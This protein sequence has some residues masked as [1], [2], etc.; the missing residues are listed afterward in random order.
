MAIT[1]PIIA[2]FNEAGV[3]KAIKQFESLTT[4]TDKAGFIMGK[5]FL[6][7]VAALG[8]ITAAAGFAV[9]AAI[10]D[11]AAQAS[12]ANTLRN[13]TQATDEQIAAT[14]TM[15]S[16]LQM[17]T[18]VADEDL[19]PAYASLTRGTK[20]VDEANKAL[21]LTLDI[22]AGA[23]VSV[24]QTADAL[25]M[26]Y[27]GNMR[28]LAA[29][30]PELKVMIKEG[31]SLDQVMATLS[32]TFAGS[33]ATAA[34]TAQGQFKRLNVALDEAKESIGK[35][36]LPAVLA[37]LPYLV[38]F[39]DWAA[40]NTPIVIGIA[41]AILGI[42]TAI[43]AVNTALALYK[44]AG[45]IAVIVNYALATSFTAANV[46]MTM[47]VA[48][49]TIAAGLVAAT[50][51]MNKFKNEN[52]ATT[53]AVAG[54]TAGLYANSQGIRDVDNAL[55]SEGRARLAS[56]GW[57]ETWN[58]TADKTV[59]GTG[60]LDTVTKKLKVTT[61]DT[62]K[63][64]AD[65]AKTLTNEMNMALD[66]ANAKLV[67]A[68]QT[69]NDFSNSVAGAITQ[70]IDFKAAWE[71]GATSGELTFGTALEEQAEKAKDF[72]DTVKK[73]I[74]AGLSEPALQQVLKA[75]VDAGTL[76]GK[77]LL[78][79]TD[80]ILKANEIVKTLNEIAALVG[81]SAAAA[82]YQSG[83]T[84][85]KAYLQGVADAMASATNALGGASTIADVKGIGATFADTVSNIGAVPTSITNPISVPADIRG[86]TGNGGN[87]NNITINTVTAPAGLGQTIVDALR[88]YEQSNGVVDI[89]FYGGFGSL[90]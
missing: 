6:P 40:R 78:S 37:V 89:N 43:I 69:F 19:R 60:K 21:A 36:L 34:G 74:A 15:I 5:A 49:V 18:G 12:L 13:T 76:I 83:V 62:N 3:Q 7:A 61:E 88:Q 53:T 14:E 46:A 82:F 70:G 48:A 44:V 17:A 73:L 51:A 42:A 87:T 11:E 1:V 55:K 67:T 56:A 72:A 59:T 57:L 52:N 45:A 86:G 4:T 38:S 66:D 80:K 9:K 85:A 90:G 71:V 68:Q 10:E 2:T 22:A 63:A 29:L 23:N 8:A 24:Q 79:S 75:G 64:V 25:A 16:K 81:T 31:A 35:A 65:L 30:S 50:I 26:A 41:G 20:N 77:E 47:G 33:A 27:G 84:D 32:R 54:T 58:T 28:A 39:G